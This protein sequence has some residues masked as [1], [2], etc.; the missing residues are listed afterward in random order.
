MYLYFNKYSGGFFP[1]MYLQKWKWETLSYC[2]SRVQLS[3]FPS[4]FLRDKFILTG[5]YFQI[6]YSCRLFWYWWLL[7][8][9]SSFKF[10]HCL[11]QVVQPGVS[12]QLITRCCKDWCVGRSA[13]S[14]NLKIFWLGEQWLH[15][16]NN[17]Y[18]LWSESE[19]MWIFF[20]CVTV[21]RSALAVVSVI[22]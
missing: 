4:L 17:C 10:F 16:F 19:I 1:K 5:Q 12:H 13:F 7:P 11:S 20:N 2:C 6:M 3:C 18:L 15:I 9:L 14:I 8:W 22:Q 21:Q